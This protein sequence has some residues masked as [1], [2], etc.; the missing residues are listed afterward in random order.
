MQPV[1][2]LGYI[3]GSAVP[4]LDS[5]SPENPSV[6]PSHAVETHPSITG[7]KGLARSVRSACQT[8]A[9]AV[10]TCLRTARRSIP[11][12]PR[13]P[14]RAS[15]SPLPR[16]PGDGR[17]RAQSPARYTQKIWSH[18]GALVDL[19][20]R[21]PLC[22]LPMATITRKQP[23]PTPLCVVCEERPA[24]YVMDCGGVTGL[25]AFAYLCRRD[26]RVL[27]DGGADPLMFRKTRG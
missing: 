12:C 21:F 14:G 26:Y 18:Y 13:C 11:R 3:R 16:M 2:S 25:P 6:A 5:Q 9:R 22:C 24:T 27:I 20:T 7:R 23:R 19:C 4:R 17:G 1:K 15:R 8:R 10:A